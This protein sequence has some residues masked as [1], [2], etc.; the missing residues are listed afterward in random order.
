MAEPEEVN[1][2][3]AEEELAADELDGHEEVE[4]QRRE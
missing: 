3:M 4:Q 2:R 1:I